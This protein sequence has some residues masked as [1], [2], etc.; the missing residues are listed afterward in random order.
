LKL[1]LDQGHDA[2]LWLAGEP[3]PSKEYVDSVK[4]LGRRLGVA[5]RVE[6]LGLR[7]DVPQIMKA[8]TAVILP[9]HSEGHP[10]VILEAMALAKPVV[11]T[12]V[13]GITDMVAPNVTGWLHEIED[14]EGLA[15]CINRIIGDPAAAEKVGKQ[16]QEYCRLS[17]A[18]AQQVQRALKVFQMCA[19]KAG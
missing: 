9:S 17:F 13:G 19:S 7:G 11:A 2:V 4:D 18:P 10:R 12:P 5:D 15:E 16:A 1:T 3:G 8:A 14:E 6:W